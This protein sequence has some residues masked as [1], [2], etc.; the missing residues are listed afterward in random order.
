[1]PVEKEETDQQILEKIMN[2]PSI[3]YEVLNGSSRRI[4]NNKLEVQL[5]F[6]W[7]ITETE[8]DHS[9]QIEMTKDEDEQM[10]LILFDKEPTEE[11]LQNHLQELT[12][13]YENI[14]GIQVPVQDFVESLRSNIQLPSTHPNGVTFDI[15]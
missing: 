15:E 6:S 3:G 9:Y 5:P 7:K 2:R 12:T 8:M 10:N 1:T 14:E 4:F 13:D 11:V